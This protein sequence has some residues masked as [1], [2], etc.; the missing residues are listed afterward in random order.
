MKEDFEKYSPPRWATRLLRWFCAPALREE[1][2]GDLEEEFE[3]QVANHGL[4]K[5]RID[6]IRNVLGFIKPFAIKRKKSSTSTAFIPMY[7]H[8]FT[9]ATRNIGRQKAFSFINIAGLALGMTCCLFIFLWVHDER[10]VDNFHAQGDKLYNVYQTIYANNAVTGNYVTTVQYKEG[11]SL[12]PIADIK[13]AVPEV[14]HLNFYATGYELPWGYPET[15]QVGDKI[16]KLEGSRASEDFFTMFSYTVLA[17]DGTNA[18]RDLS[19]IAISRKMAEM[20]FDTPENAIGKSIRYENRLD[21]VVTAVFENVPV[22]SSLKFDFLINWESQM[23]QLDSSSGKVLTTLQLT[24]N[25]DPR[26]VEDKIN[27][28]M[29]SHLDKNDPAKIRFGLQP[30][31]DQYLV[32]NFVNGKPAGGRITYVKI[33][34]GVA[35]F[36]LLLACINFMNLATARSMKRAKEIGVKKV[37]GSSRRS[38]IGQ[39][40]S[41]SMVLSFFALILSMALV[42]LLLPAFNAFTGK[43]ITS[44]VSEPGSF[45]ILLGLMVFTGFV[46]G[47]YPA[48][49]LSSL[50][51]VR[52]L[53]GSLRFSLRAIWFRKGLAVFQFAISIVFLIVAIVVSQQTRYVQT[54]HVGYDRENLIYVRVEGE[55]MNTRDQLKN[56]R[57]YTLFKEEALKMPG[58]AMIDRSSEAPHSMKF[59]V[60]EH[61]GLQETAEGDDAIQ[62]EG[63]EKGASVGFKPMSVGFDFLKIMDLKVAEGRGFSKDVASDSADA[64]MVNEEAVKQMGLKD[65]IGKWVS[66]WNK[67]GHIIGILKDYHTNSLHEPMK[68]LILDVKEYEYFGMILIRTEPGKTNEALA[69]LEKVYKDIN[70]NYPFSYQLMDQE[71]DKMYRHE[72]VITKLSNV[73]AI[74]AIIISCLG[75]LGLVMFSAEQRTKEFGIRKVLGASISNIARLLSQDFLTLILIA[76][77]IAAPLAGYLM[78]QWLQGFAFKIDLSWWIFLVAGAIA[79]FIAVATISIQAFQSGTT[80]PVKSLRSE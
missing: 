77:C 29:Q 4:R 14:A 67:K 54:V 37:V 49:F 50:K 48:L 21:F 60:D 20:F 19:S 74:L 34:T 53:K 72:Q 78:N 36:I 7:K 42:Y 8:Y 35:V 66:A 63:K 1:I 24:E 59:V 13:Q 41:E 33:F 12:I 79:L 40:L 5:A 57:T 64:F 70:P 26:Q 11:R 55:L 28:F 76:F 32:A 16:H 47:S 10:S 22:A 27:R 44:P 56:Y 3:Y 17:G 46:A 69:S 62:W 65:P 73:F 61:D 58:I 18:L 2:Q 68:P 38:L 71:Y 52:I 15:F 31:R 39:F 43:Q 75:L 25:A 23:T 51:P 30:F 80:D 45:V 9:I 6:Y